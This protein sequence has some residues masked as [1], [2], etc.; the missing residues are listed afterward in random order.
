MLRFFTNIHKNLTI[1]CNFHDLIDH[2]C[3][4]L[5][6]A[7]NQNLKKIVK[8]LPYFHFSPAAL[9]TYQVFSQ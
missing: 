9:Y 8:N 2:M 7:E 4:G 3:V 5:R 6:K 1:V